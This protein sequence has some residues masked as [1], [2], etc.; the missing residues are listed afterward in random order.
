M[1]DSCSA[2][3]I[4]RVILSHV[5]LT[6][7]YFLLV[8]QFTLFVKGHK[9]D[10][11]FEHLPFHGGLT[12]NIFRPGSADVLKWCTMNC[13]TYIN[14]ACRNNWYSCTHR[15]KNTCFACLLLVLHQLLD[16][17]WP[18]HIGVTCMLPPA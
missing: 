18:L 7:A 10:G 13:N 15:W 9:F 17:C 3:E 4:V 14:A 16:L 1:M 11:P 2:F 6:F 5:K 12:E 8:L